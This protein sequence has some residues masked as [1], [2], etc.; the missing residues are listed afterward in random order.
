MHVGVTV[1][2]DSQL[3]LARPF[4]V[5]VRDFNVKMPKEEN[6][7]RKKNV[8]D[9]NSVIVL[10]RIYCWNIRLSYNLVSYIYYLFSVN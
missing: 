3:G 6:R 1:S 4:E 8:I 9:N 5:N 10:T 7:K 2:R